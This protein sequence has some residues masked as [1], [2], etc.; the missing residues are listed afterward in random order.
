MSVIVQSRRTHKYEPSNDEWSAYKL[1]LT[2]CVDADG[3]E[4]IDDMFHS[5]HS[6]LFDVYNQFKGG[7]RKRG[8]NFADDSNLFFDIDSLQ[9]TPICSK[10]TTASK[11]SGIGVEYRTFH[12]ANC[13]GKLLP[14]WTKSY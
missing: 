7:S 8:Q 10:L 5:I 11:S 1:D 13:F 2:D 12:P 6:S 14:L 9:T 3:F 4:D